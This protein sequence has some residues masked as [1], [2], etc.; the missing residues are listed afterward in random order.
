MHRGVPRAVARVAPSRAHS[1]SAAEQR[2]LLLRQDQQK[3]LVLVQCG[4]ALGDGM[5]TALTCG[6]WSSPCCSTATD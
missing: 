3:L 2:A 4:V 5:T 1:S 6:R